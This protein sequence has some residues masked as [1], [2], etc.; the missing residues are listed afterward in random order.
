MTR[1]GQLEVNRLGLGCMGMSAVYGRPDPVEAAATLVHAVHRGVTMFDT[2]D[3][4]GSGHN[5]RFIGTVLAP[6]RDEVVL[7]SKTGI[8]TVPGVGVPRGVD[9]RPDRIRRAVDASLRRLGTDRIDLYYLHRVDPRVPIEESVGA[10]AEAAAAGKVREI[11]VSEVTADELRRA[12]ATHPIAAAQLE[13][14]LFSRDK[15]TEVIPTARELGIAVV[16]YSP[17]GRGMLTGS[18]AATTDLPL[19]DYRRFLPRWSRANVTANVAAVATVRAIADELGVT[20][21]RVALAW[22]LAQGEDVIPIPGTKRRRYLEDN[23][24]AADVCLSPAH[25]DVLGAIAPS[26]ARYGFDPTGSI[27]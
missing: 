18:P 20:P 19:L 5:E 8:L 9:A 26:G 2:A 27:S 12:H 24:A 1:I 11:G 10:L 23:L 13:W 3:M 25:L 6:Y 14:S 22:L 17:L 7:A 21:G 16:C 4:Y 15:E